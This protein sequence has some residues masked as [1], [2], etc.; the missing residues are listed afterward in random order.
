MP[1]PI[2]VI[3][4]D[5]NEWRLEL[6]KMYS[7]ILRG[8][9][10]SRKPDPTKHQS[11]FAFSTALE[12]LEFLRTKARGDRAPKSQVDILSLD[13]NLKHESGGTGVDVLKRAVALGNK[14]VSIIISGYADDDELAEQLG[15]KEYGRLL[16]LE[17]FATGL[18]RCPSF[19]WDKKKNFSVVDQVKAIETILVSKYP[20]G[21]VL[22]SLA[23]DLQ[24]PSVAD[25]NGKTLCLHFEL[26]S[27]LVKPS[28]KRCFDLRDWEEVDQMSM[29]S[30]VFKRRHPDDEFEF[31]LSDMLTKLI[32][33]ADPPKPGAGQKYPKYVAGLSLQDDV[34]TPAKKEDWL[35]SSPDDLTPQ[36]CVFFLRLIASQEPGRAS[37]KQEKPQTSEAQV[38]PILPELV[39]TG[40]E[41]QSGWTGKNHS[42]DKPKIYRPGDSLVVR[43]RDNAEDSRSQAM[44]TAISRLNTK[45]K[46]LLG[47]VNFD[48]VENVDKR[49][50]VQ[51]AVE[52]DLDSDLPSTFA[53][54]GRGGSFFIHRV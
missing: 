47:N 51:N 31:D 53:L 5:N 14:F 7:R 13:L 2:V 6:T 39:I 40:L 37:G 43:L 46:R 28:T 17:A 21:N 10:N 19:S 32:F 11:V 16:S 52:E 48:V 23:A 54:A 25:L 3:V 34:A 24:S 20:Q 42:K 1:D 35:T 15:T 9:T 41:D 18:T 8:E 29:W 50:R 36:E 49:Y 44:A 22:R 26:P 30:G 12:A 27:E 33:L 45:L 38:V 4:E